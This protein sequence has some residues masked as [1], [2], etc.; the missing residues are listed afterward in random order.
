MRILLFL[1]DN[2]ANDI[3]VINISDVLGKNIFSSKKRING[4]LEESIDISSF[5]QGT[6]FIEVFNTNTSVVETITIE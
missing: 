2:V 5:G 1:I 3:Y 4:Y 6:Y